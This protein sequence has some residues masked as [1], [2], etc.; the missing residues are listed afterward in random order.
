MGRWSELR[1]LN[2]ELFPPVIKILKRFHNI[3]I[4]YKNTTISSSVKGNS[5]T[6]EPFLP[7]R[8]PYLYYEQNFIIVLQIHIVMQEVT[9]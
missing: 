8:I 1:D 4:V 5:Q 3:D 2:Q 7:S 9:Q 6:L